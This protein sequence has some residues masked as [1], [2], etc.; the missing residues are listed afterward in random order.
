V[1]ASGLFAVKM[2][3]E[4]IRAFFGPTDGNRI[5]MRRLFKIVAGHI[6]QGVV[7]VALRYE[8]YHFETVIEAGRR[9]P[10]RLLVIVKIASWTAMCHMGKVTLQEDY[11]AN[12]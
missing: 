12:M 4:S 9:R 5:M 3:L 6:V 2:L 8:E 7:S 11:F 1:L 10:R